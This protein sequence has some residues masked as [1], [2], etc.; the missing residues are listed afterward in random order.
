MI[1]PIPFA[2][3]TILTYATLPLPGIQP[4]LMDESGKE[5]IENQVNGRLC[6]KFPWPGMARTIWGNHD[7]YRDTYFSAYPS[8]Q[9]LCL[10]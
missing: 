9:V 6:I 8:V 2:T 1:A 10:L 7:R 3:P 4:V 5:L